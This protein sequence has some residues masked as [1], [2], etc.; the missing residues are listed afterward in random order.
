MVINKGLRRLIPA[1]NYNPG[2]NILA[3]RTLF[4]YFC[5]YFP[6]PTMD[7]LLRTLVPPPTSTLLFSIKSLRTNMFICVNNIDIGERGV[8]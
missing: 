6:T 1:C 7:K 3:K 8:I 2:Q 5:K 4:P